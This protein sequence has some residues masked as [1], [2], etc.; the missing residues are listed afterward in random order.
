MVEGSILAKK[1]FENET[2]KHVDLDLPRQP[3]LYG[4]TVTT[5]DVAGNYK[6]ARRFVYFD[7]SSKLMINH[8]NKLRFES[9]NQDT[10]FTWQTNHGKICLSW[11]DRYY[12]NFNVLATNNVLKK[13]QQNV[14]YNGIYEQTIGVLPINGTPNVHGL[15]QFSY[16]YKLENNSFTKRRQVP[17]FTRQNLCETI[18]VQDGESYEFEI[19]SMDLKSQ[20]LS[21][22]KI[23]HIDASVPNINNIWLVKEDDRQLYVHNSTQL[24]EMDIEFDVWDDHSGVHSIH[25]TFGTPENHNELGQGAIGVKSIKTNVSIKLCQQVYLLDRIFYM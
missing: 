14:L 19:Q 6:K 7:N 1:V 20:K 4:I 17:N 18:S 23:V 5:V 15:I 8:N 9:A 2:G 25:W 21:E 3:A 22:G 11:T 16:R 13:L 12:N 24:S 10:N